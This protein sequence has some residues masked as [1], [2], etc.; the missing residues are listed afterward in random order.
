MTEHFLERDSSPSNAVWQKLFSLS[1]SRRSFK[2]AVGVGPQRYV[3]Q[4]RIERAKTLMRCTNHALTSIAEE[5]GL[6]DQG[7]LMSIFHREMGTTPSGYRAEV[8]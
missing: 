3:M 7:H 8:G 2:Q 1:F 5:V 4:R 6:T